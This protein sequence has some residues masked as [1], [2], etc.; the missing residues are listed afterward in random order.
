[1]SKIDKNLSK[2]IEPLIKA[3]AEYVKKTHNI[4]PDKEV[5]GWGCDLV[6]AGGCAA[7]CA[8][9]GEVGSV[10]GSTGGGAVADKYV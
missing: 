7:I 3:V 9:S 1:M 2:D 4:A 10:L 8:I 5:A 6:C